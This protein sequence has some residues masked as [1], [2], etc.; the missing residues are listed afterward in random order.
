MVPDFGGVLIDNP[1]DATALRLALR[2]ALEKTWDEGAIRT[3]AAAH[4]WSDVAVRVLEQ[5]VAARDVS[6]FVAADDAST[7]AGR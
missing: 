2:E 1:D 7:Q 6:M 3:Y 5:W 4:T